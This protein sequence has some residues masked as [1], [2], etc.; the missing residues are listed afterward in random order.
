M[1]S[2]L[3]SSAQRKADLERL[4]KMREAASTPPTT[5]PGPA[6]A[7]SRQHRDAF[8]AKYDRDDDTM[9]A[10][11]SIVGG[12]LTAAVLWHYG[13]L[14]LG[15]VVGLLWGGLVYAVAGWEEEKRRRKRDRDWS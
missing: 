8:F 9:N 3:P 14:A 11:A 13:S 2:D 5:A 1:S 10:I 7:N 6:K 4:L 15:L 12:V